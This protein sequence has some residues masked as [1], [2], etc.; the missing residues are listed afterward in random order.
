MLAPLPHYL[1]VS[2]QPWYL[3]PLG[4]SGAHTRCQVRRAQFEGPGELVWSATRFRR[5]RSLCPIRG[6]DVTR[7]RT[8]PLSGSLSGRLWEAHGGIIPQRVI[9][10]WPVKS[11]S[12]EIDWN[13]YLACIFQPVLRLAVKCILRVS[14]KRKKMKVR[15]R[16]CVCFLPP[17][18]SSSKE[19]IHW[20]NFNWTHFLSPSIV[21]SLFCN[22]SQNGLSSLSHS[23]SPLSQN[24]RRRRRRGVWGGGVASW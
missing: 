17:H 6:A 10:K 13:K 7:A 3:A 23:I 20:F 1:A 11:S 4:R 16:V 19:G 9:S 14:L 2:L 8:P 15:A 18:S 5:G 12:G 22:G 21:R 24:D